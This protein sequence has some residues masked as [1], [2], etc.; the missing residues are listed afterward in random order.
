[1][2]LR[3]AQLPL[4]SG[5]IDTG[6]GCS[7]RAL[8]R[9]SGLG[10]GWL[11]YAV[12]ANR[13]P[14]ATSAATEPSRPQLHVSPR[15]KRVIFLF[16]DGGVSQVDSFDPK[17]ELDRLN[18]Q[19]A[20]W[21]PD[22]KSQS[23]S[24]GRKWLG[25]PWKFARH[26]QSGLWVSE[27]FP[28]A[29]KM[30]DDL[31]VVRSMVG[32][33]PLHGAQ[34]LLLHTGRSVAAA[35]SIGSWVSYGLAQEDRELPGYVLLNND[36]IP[37]GGFQNFASSFLPANHQAALVRAKGTPVDNIA[38]ADPVDVQRAK[39]DFLRDTDM[40]F[41]RT[42]RETNRASSNNENASTGSASGAA[43]AIE[44]SIRNYETA[45][46]MQ[47]LVPSLCDVAGETAET[48][49][50]YGVDRGNDY[51][52]LYALQCLRARRFAEAGV[53]FIEVTCPNTHGNNSPWDQHGDLRRRHAENA[54]ITDQPVAAL[55]IDLKRR[56][57]LDETLVVWAGEMGRTPHSSGNDG[58]DH[59]V[60]GYSIWMAGGGVRGGMAYGATDEM[61]MSAVEN[62]LDIHD[63][64]ATILHL[65]GLDHERLTFRFGGR[66][67][68]LTDVHGRV[69]RDLMIS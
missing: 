48:L 58:R 42:L 15:A 65:L 10:L 21:R 57:L 51:E 43:A 39:L 22:P 31:C 37:N 62:P 33:T 34:S 64:H 32:E 6:H 68:R 54:R 19:P 1:M 44:A 63:L 38:A 29:A 24:A 55:L 3:N 23:V 45:A 46:R 28:H 41:A 61:G 13:F 40:D 16:M 66:D 25:S 52:K 4:E 60:S 11:A 53:G 69:I 30:A 14:R 56:G 2:S 26:G 50:L 8:L 59:H 47:T 27:L 7:R 18:G 17:P 9:G 35:P 67:M 49:A 12:M 20:K 36:W 5:G